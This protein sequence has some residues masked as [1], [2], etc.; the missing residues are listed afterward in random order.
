MNINYILIGVAAIVVGAAIFVSLN[1]GYIDDWFYDIPEVDGSF[2]RTITIGYMDGTTEVI[3]ELNDPFSVF[4]G[5]KQ[6][7]DVRYDFKGTL[8][9]GADHIWF[10]YMD[11]DIDWEVRKAGTDALIWQKPDAAFNYQS[12][13]Y[14]LDKGAVDQLMFGSYDN[15]DWMSVLQVSGDYYINI[16]IIGDFS[17]SLEEFSGYIDIPVDDVVKI[18]IS[19]IHEV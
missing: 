4:Y 15:I 10:K 9:S 16:K 1:L 2:D 19:Y 7:K 6:V 14:E 5:D 3:G 12:S 8:T 18:P 11:A 13:Y 17:Y